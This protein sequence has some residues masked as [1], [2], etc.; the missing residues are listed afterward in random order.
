MSK[1][2]VRHVPAYRAARLTPQTAELYS[3]IL[4]CLSEN[5]FYRMAECTEREVAQRLDVPVRMVAA[6][7]NSCS[8]QN[9]RSVLNGYRL[10]DAQ[11]MLRSARYD[12]YTAEEIGLMS[13]F[14]SRQAFYNA[15]ARVYD[16]TP[17]AFRQQHRA[18]GKEEEEP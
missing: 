6:T 16:L 3:R 14:A 10:R 1:A 18:Q 2:T 11:F 7:I 15:F 9:F 13:G 4:Q 17:R 12:T 5:R 8:G